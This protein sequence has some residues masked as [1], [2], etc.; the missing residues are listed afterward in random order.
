MNYDPTTDTLYLTYGEPNFTKT[1]RKTSKAP[2][3]PTKPITAKKQAAFYQRIDKWLVYEANEET[4][5][6]KYDYNNLDANT[7][8]EMCKVL[9]GEE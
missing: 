9:G 6:Y 1:G 3:P 8:R 4:L 5:S 7:R 2:N